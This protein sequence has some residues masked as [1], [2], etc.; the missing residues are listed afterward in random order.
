LVVLDQFT[1][2]I[3]GFGVQAVTLDGPA[4]CRMF[5]QAIPGQG[6]PTRLSTDHDPLFRFHRWR[7]SL[8]ILEVETVQ[9]VPQVPCSHPFVGRLIATIRRE[10]LDRLFFLTA[11]DLE[12]ELELFK[13]YYNSHQGLSGDTPGEKAGDPT[14]QP[15]SLEN[16]RWQ[17]HCHGLFELPIAA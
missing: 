5:N 17:N 8:R 1:R 9:T 3:V 6:L 7:A 12:R 16:Y 15:A 14:P 13:I 2:R 11:N 10:Y 4:L